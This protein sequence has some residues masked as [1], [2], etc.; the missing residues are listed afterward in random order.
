MAEITYRGIPAVFDAVSGLFEWEKFAVDLFVA[1]G[2]G[3]ELRS[4]DEVSG[5]V[6][7]AIRLGRNFEL[8]RDNKGRF[9]NTGERVREKVEELLKSSP[10]CLTQNRERKPCEVVDGDPV[11]YTYRNRVERKLPSG[12]KSNG[13]VD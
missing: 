4:K 13:W 9:L 6:A 1:Q 7:A 2:R 10:F 3:I 8:T 12:R 5:A 11:F